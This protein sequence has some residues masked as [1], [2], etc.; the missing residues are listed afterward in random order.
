[1]PG[2][3]TRENFDLAGFSVGI[4]EQSQLID[5]NKIKAGQVLLA[6]EC[7]GPHS[8]GYSYEILRYIEGY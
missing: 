4:V 5:G 2:H 1:M 3:Y 8:N 6:I 7:S